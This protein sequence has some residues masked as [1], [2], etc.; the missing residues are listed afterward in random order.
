MKIETVM[1]NKR[2]YYIVDKLEI[3]GNIY[4]LLINEKDNSDICVRKKSEENEVE[5]LIGL[6]SEE[7]FDMVMNVYFNQ[8][9]NKVS[10][11]IF[12]IGTLVKLKNYERKVMITGYFMKN[13]SGKI[14]EYCGCE[15]PQGILNEN[16]YLYF[17]KNDIIKIIKSGYIDEEVKD[18]LEKVKLARKY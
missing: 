18:V 11:N 8:K 9:K 3:N 5:Y 10:E 2:E 15:Y 1:I 6:D 4:Y 16:S 17:N 14:Y 13:E 12:P 7:E